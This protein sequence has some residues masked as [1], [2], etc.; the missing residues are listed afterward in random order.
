MNE[1]IKMTFLE[2]MKPI[3]LELARHWFPAD[4]KT[5]CGGY[6]Y[7]CT[8]CDMECGRHVR[9]DDTC[10]YQMAKNTV[11]KWEEIDKSDRW[12]LNWKNEPRDPAEIEDMRQ[13]SNTGLSLTTSLRM[14]ATLFP[15][16][17]QIQETRV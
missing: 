5:P 2:D 4:K 3:I 15:W 1:Q 14:L 8:Y 17:S 12:D 11:E 13:F 9:H 10:L 7:A 6:Y 16:I